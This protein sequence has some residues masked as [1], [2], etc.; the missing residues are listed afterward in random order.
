MV[1]R[2]TVYLPW[3]DINSAKLQQ[4]PVFLC[5]VQVVTVDLLDAKQMQTYSVPSAL[6]CKGYI[7]L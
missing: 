2:G 3:L 4:N 6:N 1:K 5:N 7:P